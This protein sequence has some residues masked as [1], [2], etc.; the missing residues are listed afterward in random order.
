[1]AYHRR[2]EERQQVE[3]NIDGQPRADFQRERQ[4]EQSQQERLQLD[5]AGFSDKPALAEHQNEADQVKRKRK[6]PKKWRGSDIR[7]DVGCRRDH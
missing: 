4:H 3:R 6:H 7:R 5:P 1:M 2:D